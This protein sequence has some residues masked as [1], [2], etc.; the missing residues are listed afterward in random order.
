M[1]TLSVGTFRL[2]LTVQELH[3]LLWYLDFES[4]LLGVKHG[5]FG[6]FLPDMN[7][8]KNVTPDFQKALLGVEVRTHHSTNRMCKYPEPFMQVVDRRGETIKG[9]ETVSF[10]S[11]PTGF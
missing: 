10:P 8:H 1:Y 11:P 4:P 3:S 9:K 2:D 5:S 6:E 7:F